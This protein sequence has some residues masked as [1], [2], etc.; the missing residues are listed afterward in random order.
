MIA[1]RLVALQALVVALIAVAFGI[2]SS[3]KAGSVLLG[4]AA[5]VLPSFAFARF[6]FTT[7]SSRAAKK[8]I[9]I[10]FLGE[11]VKLAISAALVALIVAFIPVALMP[12][13]VGFAGAQFGFWLAPALVKIDVTKSSA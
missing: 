3:L 2:H 5:C 12:F 11:L 10:F 6:L 9:K 8:I 13:I 7:T 4:G 1:Y